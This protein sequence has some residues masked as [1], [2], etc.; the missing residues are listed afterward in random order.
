MWPGSFAGAVIALPGVAVS[1]IIGCLIMWAAS[2]FFAEARRTGELELL[3]ATPWGASNLLRDHWKALARLL[4][5][6]LLVQVAPHLIYIPIVWLNTNSSQSLYGFGYIVL[7]VGNILLS[8]IAA[9]WLGIW[10]GLRARNPLGAIVGA[11]CV[12][13]LVPN[14][15]GLILKVVLVNVLGIASYL[16][17]FAGVFLVGNVA[18]LTLNMLFNA[19][20]ISFAS[21]RVNQALNSNVRGYSA[22]SR[23]QIGAL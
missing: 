11:A 12:I 10:I 2:R 7:V 22:H 21:R 16:G 8:V 1:I 6:P 14:L 17:P 9:C 5:P 3:L 18:P 20:L 15:V 19:W 4:A 23:E 13:K